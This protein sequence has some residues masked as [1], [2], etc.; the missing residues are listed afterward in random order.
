MNLGS[1]EPEILGVSGFLAVKLPLGPWDPGVNKPLVSWY[2]EIVRSW[3]CYNSWKWC[4]LRDCGAVLCVWNQ[5]IPTQIRRI[6]SHWP[7][8]APMS[9]LLLSLACHA[10]LEQIF[11]STHWWSSDPAVL[12]CLQCAESFEDHG[13][14][15]WVWV[16]GGQELAPT[17]RDLCPWS[18]R[19]PASLLLAQAG[20]D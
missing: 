7:G 18:S 19:F 3:A 6:I 2:P 4:L 17:R 14:I 9:L 13:T 12:G 5:H 15:C 8:R 10:F 20:H 16:Q 1:C 11:C